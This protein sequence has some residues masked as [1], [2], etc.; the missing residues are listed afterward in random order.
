MNDEQLLGRLP[1]KRTWLDDI[2]AI[3]LRRP[4]GEG[5]VDAIVTSLL[6]TRREVGAEVEAT[7]TRTINNFCI[8]TGDTE[9]KVRYRLFQRTGP[10]KYKLL[11]YP[12]APDLLEIQEVQ[13]SNA[14][15]QHVWKFFVKKIGSDPRWA[16]MSKRERLVAFSRSLIESQLM[17]GMLDEYGALQLDDQPRDKQSR[18]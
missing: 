14:A 12:D 8:N 2:V 3:L 15:H 5:E 10:A 17:Q 18:A 13:F 11:T 1:L 9:A 7:V 6:K 16:V 4:N